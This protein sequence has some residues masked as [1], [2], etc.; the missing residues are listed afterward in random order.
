[1]GTLSFT[2]T[3]AGRMGR[4]GDAFGIPSNARRVSGAHSTSTTASTVQASSVNVVLAHGEIFRAHADEAM[5][6]AFGGTT[7]AIGTGFYIPANQT[8][9]VECTLTGTISVIDVA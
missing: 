4:H 2:V 9:A 7:A 6:I 3:E 5:W 8:I 1:M